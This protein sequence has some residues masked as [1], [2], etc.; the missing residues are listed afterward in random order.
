M[1]SRSHITGWLFDL[2]KKYRLL[3]VSLHVPVFHVVINWKDFPSIDSSPFQVF[4]NF[5]NIRDRSMPRVH[6]QCMHAHTNTQTCMHAPSDPHQ[7]HKHTNINTQ[8][9]ALSHTDA[10]T[11]TLAL[12]HKHAN[13]HTNLM[14][15][16][17]GS[18]STFRIDLMLSW[19]D[20]SL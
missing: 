11:H 5:K 9:M 3:R 19:G 16:I 6:R 12:S 10:N 7:T 2:S 17:V 1:P 20:L 8:T 15:N 14:P 4:P 18:I 13:T